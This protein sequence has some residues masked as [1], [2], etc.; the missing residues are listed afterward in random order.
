MVNI[1]NLL[2]KYC[3]YLKKTRH[4]I[5]KIKYCISSVNFN[6][7]ITIRTENQAIICSENCNFL[8]KGGLWTCSD[9]SKSFNYPR[10]LVVHTILQC[11]NSHRTIRTEEEQVKPKSAAESQSK[12]EDRN[13]HYNNFVKSS[14]SKELVHKFSLYEA[15]NIDEQGSRARMRITGPRK[16]R[17]SSDADTID[18]KEIFI[19][20]SFPSPFQYIMEAD[21]ETTCNKTRNVDTEEN[22]TDG[23]SLHEGDDKVLESFD[24][25]QDQQS[26]TSLPHFDGSVSGHKHQTSRFSNLLTLLSSRPRSVTS[27]EKKSLAEFHKKEFR[28]KFQGNEHY[29]RKHLYRGGP[30]ND[31]V[32]LGQDKFTALTTHITS[33]SLF[34][35][36]NG[37]QFST[38]VKEERESALH[39]CNGLNRKHGYLSENILGHES[40]EYSRLVDERHFHYIHQ[41][42]QQ[43]LQSQPPRIMKP[44]RYQ[45][46]LRCN[47]LFHR[48][49]FDPWLSS[50]KKSFSTESKLLL[51]NNGHGDEASMDVEVNNTLERSTVIENTKAQSEPST[52]RE[53]HSQSSCP[54]PFSNENSVE[55]SDDSTS[56]ENNTSKRTTPREGDFVSP[57]NSDNHQFDL[58]KSNS[59]SNLKSFSSVEPDFR[60][61]RQQTL[62]RN[63]DFRLYNPFAKAKAHTHEHEH[64]H[65]LRNVAAHPT[66]Q[67]Y[68]SAK[69]NI[70]LYFKPLSIPGFIH[71]YMSHPHLLPYMTPQAVNH[72]PATPTRERGFTCDFCG[73][74]YC[75]KYVL[76]IHMR[77]HTGFKPLHC[78]VCDKSFSDPS[79][80]KKHVKLHETE[81]TVHKCKYCGRNFVRYRGLLNHIKAKHTSPSEFGLY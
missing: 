77:T 27:L 54:S 2:S 47:I 23:A 53:S 11:G 17:L 50:R 67:S 76:K 78:K 10:K 26:P 75:R 33:S 34:R 72:L 19:A 35:L 39:C 12:E 31:D 37:I 21:T 22:L 15:A 5:K 52:T 68:Q 74:V 8:F 45:D 14:G 48:S 79:N 20:G 63:E 41:S 44:A 16:R 65:R 32:K 46:Y 40:S 6:L 81:N 28:K 80:M 71:P 30:S 3:N 62:N 73:K 49:A 36:N 29:L 55:R 56:D 13:L 25:R 38:S 57:T 24:Q 51:D 61:Y 60:L 42:S 66:L 70:P 64:E 58:E 7:P 4:Y 18:V 59:L 9:C 43:S 1:A 69:D